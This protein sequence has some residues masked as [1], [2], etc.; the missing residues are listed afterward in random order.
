MMQDVIH[1]T[2]WGFKKSPILFYGN[3]SFKVWLLYKYF[4]AVNDIN[5]L[6]GV[7]YLAAL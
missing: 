1:K 3:C 6:C 2:R 5:T 7:L 4:L